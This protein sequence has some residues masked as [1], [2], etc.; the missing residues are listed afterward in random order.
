MEGKKELKAVYEIFLSVPMM[1]DLVNVGAK[2][3][4]KHL[5]L[6]VQLF[7]AAL[8]RDQAMLDSLH[9]ILSK[10]EIEELNTIA[11]DFLQKVGLTELNER[12]R[13]FSKQ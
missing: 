4:R 7:Q 2:V 1:S 3:S 6:L 5:L 10:A 12:L 13:Q 8:S 9:G 11:I